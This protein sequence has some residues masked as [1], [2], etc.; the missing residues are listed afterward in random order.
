[1]AITS[2]W[3]YKSED[4]EERGDKDIDGSKLL[5]DKY[6]GSSHKNVDYIKLEWAGHS[7]VYTNKDYYDGIKITI[8][9]PGI[10]FIKIK[11]SS[12]VQVNKFL[13]GSE[14][15]YFRHIYVEEEDVK[16]IKKFNHHVILNRHS[17]DTALLKKDDFGS[18]SGN[19][20]LELDEEFGPY[21]RYRVNN[22]LGVKSVAEKD[23]DGNATGNFILKIT[24]K[25]NAHLSS[26]SSASGTGF[27]DLAVWTEKGW[28]RVRVRDYELLIYES[29]GKTLA[30]KDSSGNIILQQGKAY[31][32]KIKETHG[33]ANDTVIMEMNNFLTKEGDSL[34]DAKWYD[35][36]G[37]K[38]QNGIISCVLDEYELNFTSGDLKIGKKASTGINKINLDRRINWGGTWSYVSIIA[39]INV[40][41]VK[42]SGDEEE[43][44][45]DINLNGG[46]LTMFD[47]NGNVSKVFKDEDEPRCIWVKGE[48][49]RIPGEENP[50]YTIK[51]DGHKLLGWKI[52]GE[53]DLLKEDSG[54]QAKKMTLHA[55]WEKIEVV[56]NDPPPAVLSKD[57]LKDMKNEP[58]DKDT[59][60]KYVENKEDYWN[61]RTSENFSSSTNKAGQ[62]KNGDVI[63]VVEVGNS[64][65]NGFKLQIEV[66]EQKNGTLKAGRGSGS[67]KLY[68]Y[69]SV[70]G[71]GTGKNAS[72]NLLVQKNYTAP[73]VDVEPP[74]KPETTPPPEI[75]EEPQVV[76]TLTYKYCE[77]SDGSDRTEGVAVDGGKKN[78][79]MIGDG[80]EI[81][82][83]NE[84]DPT[85][86]GKSRVT[87]SREGYTFVGWASEPNSEVADITDKFGGKGS[88]KDLEP[89]ERY[90]CIEENTTIYAVWKANEIK[91][92]PPAA[93]NPPA[94]ENPPV[95]AFNFTGIIQTIIEMIIKI[96]TEID[97][98]EVITTGTSIVGGIISSV[99]G[100]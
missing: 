81:V 43:V 85:G 98:A 88:N 62:L 36:R 13:A 14:H 16:F 7:D 10:Y 64:D 76:Y 89:K 70:K 33:N 99:T 65:Q 78:E 71:Y 55:I 50:G 20:C 96:I 94:V 11:L 80:A 29:D 41:T 57:Q 69:Y 90:L 15:Y 68:I 72:E 87:L 60:L 49:Y 95:D 44:R 100:S 30:K 53:G 74:P 82:I 58:I 2:F 18:I 23:K 51:K 17:G 84:K 37:V 25:E 9:K 4:G 73:V 35:N 38:E 39:N 26:N 21:M 19:V 24:D 12:A 48:S 28:I 5:A 47:D 3:I 52:N 97:W 8:N 93:E 22:N 79:F 31:K 77:G 42:D 59:Y 92:E 91:T 83:V 86:T 45:V 67:E 32:L 54:I 1:M 27:V 61:V 40:T 34:K 56:N 75:D 63:K 46:T 66:C 6:T